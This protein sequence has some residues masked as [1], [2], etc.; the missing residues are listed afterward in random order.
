LSYRNVEEMLSER[1]SELDRVGVRQWVQ[2]V[3]AIAR[4]EVVPV[5]LES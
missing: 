4:R 5:A 3:H 2:Q 1:G